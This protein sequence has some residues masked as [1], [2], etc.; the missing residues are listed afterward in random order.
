VFAPLLALTL[1]APVEVFEEWALT[2]TTP[3]AEVVTARA[4]YRRRDGD[5][6]LLPASLRRGPRPDAFALGQSAPLAVAW[7][8]R[9]WQCALPP[10]DRDAVRVIARVTRRPEAPRLFRA[11]WPA[12]PAAEA[13]T[14]RLA[15]VPRDWLDGR[16]AGWTCPDEPARDV[17]CVSR[18]PRPE[19]LVTRVPPATSAPG[20]ALLAST[21][22]ALTCALA[23]WPERRRA[24]RVFAALGGLAV[25]LSTAL[26]LVGGRVSSWGVAAALCLPAGALVGALAPATAVGR[27]V[28]AGALVVVPAAAVLGA[29]PRARARA[30]ACSPPP[31]SWAPART[32]P[33][34]DRRAARGGCV[35]V[36]AY[37]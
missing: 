17:P 36:G 5:V 20:S 27:A 10:G 8:P 6:A 12:V 9:G 29:S 2:D 13:P 30:R 32:R 25:A 23:A 21:L 15:V 4:L 18:D 19:A 3:M 1:A 31:P 35:S 11:R 22:T 16:H 14:R 34:I 26:S 37:G 7:G 24:E 28:G 33:P